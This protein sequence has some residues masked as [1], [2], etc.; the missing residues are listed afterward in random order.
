LHF[1]LLYLV[2]N[3]QFLDF[4]TLEAFFPNPEKISGFDKK[5]KPGKPDRAY[6]SAVA[7]N[8]GT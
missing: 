1:D 2:F 8:H 6:F 4:Q 5:G 7:E 3:E